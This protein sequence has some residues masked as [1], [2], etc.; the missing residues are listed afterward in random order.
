MLLT[1]NHRKN[2]RECITSTHTLPL[3]PISTQISSL[4]AAIRKANI[5]WTS[6]VVKYDGGNFYDPIFL[7]VVTLAWGGR[8]FT[9]LIF[10]WPSVYFLRYI[11]LPRFFL[12]FTSSICLPLTCTLFMYFSLLFD[13]VTLFVCVTTTK[14]IIGAGTCRNETTNIRVK[15]YVCVGVTCCCPLVCV[16]DK[17]SLWWISC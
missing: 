9:L 11:F 1:V 3:I 13:C 15:V 14:I 17:D 8:V 6:F 10:F 12:L 7:T 5:F 16:Q 4:W 2:T